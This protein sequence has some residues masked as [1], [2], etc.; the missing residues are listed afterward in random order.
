MV[1]VQG[2]TAIAAAPIGVNTTTFSIRNTGVGAAR[3]IFF[4][5]DY[6]A[7]VTTVTL[8]PPAGVTLA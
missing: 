3:T 7:G 6:P 4:S 8:T 2:V 1:T 5:I